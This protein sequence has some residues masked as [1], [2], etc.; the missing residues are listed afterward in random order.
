MID[1]DRAAEFMQTHARLIDRRRF[2]LLFGNGDSDGAL[3][4]L[5]GH[6]NAD[7]G[8][9]WAMEPDL[10]GAS[11]QPAGALHAFEVLEEIAP[12]TSPLAERLCDWL[13]S[14]SLADGGLPF[15]LPGAG[16]GSAP[17]WVGADPSRSSLHITSAVCGIAHR[18]AGHDPAVA[19]HA[20]LRRAT[21]YCL[22]EIPAL[23]RPGGATGGAIE[24]MYVLQL[25]DTLCD[26]NAAAARE[27]DRL[28]TFIPASGS[29]P[30]RGGLED[31]KLT[32]LDF[33][34]LPDRPV[35][36]LFEPE[37]VARDLD[38]LEAE[39][40][41]DGGWDVDFRSYSPAGA[42]EWRGYATVRALKILRANGR[43]ETAARAAPG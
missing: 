25:V 31:E 38:R 42:L 29:M 16:A 23:E 39:Q 22:K 7:G 33:A 1:L 18:V 28:A 30:V 20:W 43:L 35:R 4:A 41:D 11:S 14:A 8:F 27:L 17:F 36:K 32:P 19:A 26:K 10:R 34:P 2:D 5:A 3:A 9:G 21:D 40:H 12:A 24:F 6:A 13:D 37:P 15:A